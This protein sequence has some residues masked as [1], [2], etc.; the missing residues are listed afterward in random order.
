MSLSLELCPALTQFSDQ[1]G[2]YAKIT[3]VSIG[4]ASPPTETVTLTE[5]EVCSSEGV[6]S[7]FV[8]D[9]VLCLD[10]CLN[11]YSLWKW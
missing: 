5:V 2:K 3:G 10:C 6:V 9:E 4:E 11:C 1:E 7:T 8:S